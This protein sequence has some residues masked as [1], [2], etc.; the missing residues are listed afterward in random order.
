MYPRGPGQPARVQWKIVTRAAAVS[1]VVRL[2]RVA[3]CDQG[4]RGS[5]PSQTFVTGRARA[6]LEKP[7]DP[8]A[9]SSKFS[10]HP[11][12][13]C[14]T[15]G[16]AVRYPPVPNDLPGR[17]RP[18]EGVYI[19]MDQPTIVFMTVGTD[20]REP[21]LAQKLVQDSLELTWRE[22]DGWSVG[23]YLLMPDHLHLFCAPRDLSFTLEQW[24]KFWKSRFKRRHLDQPWHF[25]RAG[26]DTRLRRQESYSQKWNYVRENP[27]R[28]GL[29]SHPDDWPYQGM[30][31]ELRW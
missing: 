4:Q 27:V 29:V 23:Y 11:G 25:Q 7:L 10:R 5:C 20:H 15:I 18:A 1:S 17:K 31:N 14:K 9:R 30:I 26:W 21:W 6:I 13:T 16:F 3:A 8:I 24:L 19:R 12:R 2:S 28:K 22:A